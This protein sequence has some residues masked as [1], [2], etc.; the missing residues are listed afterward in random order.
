LNV[1]E[2]GK[3]VFVPSPYSNGNSLSAEVPH[4]NVELLWRLERIGVRLL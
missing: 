4:S 3:R 1:G 2:E